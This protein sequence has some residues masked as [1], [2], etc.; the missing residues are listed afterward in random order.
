MISL[1]IKSYLAILLSVSLGAILLF[2]LGVYL[3]FRYFYGNVM[4]A[5]A[6]SQPPVIDLH[7]SELASIAGDDLIATQLDLAR[8]YLEIDNHPAAIKLLESISQQ[9][10][11]GQKSDAAKLLDHLSDLQFIQHVKQTSR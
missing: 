9:G 6:V 11:A 5:D 10:N 2:S 8:A 7:A 1:I 4:A 3:I